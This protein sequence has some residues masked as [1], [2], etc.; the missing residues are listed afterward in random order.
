MNTTTELPKD[1]KERFENEKRNWELYGPLGMGINYQ[2]I[3]SWFAQELLKERDSLLKKI[4]E[5]DHRIIIQDQNRYISFSKQPNKGDLYVRVKEVYSI[6]GLNI[7][8]L[9][10]WFKK[11]NPQPKE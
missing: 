4:S 1:V 5:V 2:K 11:T 6:L 7:E 9:P 10:D 8:D 3:E